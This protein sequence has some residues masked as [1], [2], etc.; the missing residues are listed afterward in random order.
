MMLLAIGSSE[1]P[2]EPSG[3]TKASLHYK[4]E[5]PV[6]FLM[7]VIKLIDLKINHIL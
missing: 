7:V 6:V 5:T 4:Q 2:G 3:A 1:I